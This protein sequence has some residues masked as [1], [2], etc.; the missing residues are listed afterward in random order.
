MKKMSIKQLA[1]ELDI[2][3]ATISYIMNGK[4]RE[5]RISVDLEEKVKKYAIEHNYKPNQLASGLRS[6]KTKII[7]LMVEDIA[8]VFFAT[9]A[10]HIEQIAYDKGYKIVYCSTKNDT[11]K[12]QELINTF[13]NRNVD[14]Y[15]ITP[16]NG[17][18]QDI[19]SLIE[20][21][22][23]V[24]TF[25]RASKAPN[26]S[27]VGMDNFESSFKA[28]NH[29]LEQGYQNIAL[30]TLD[31]EQSQMNE[32]L[33]GYEKA[34]KDSGKNTIIEKIEYTHRHDTAIID[35]IEK[36]LVTNSTIDAVYFATNYLAVSGLDAINRLS[37]KIPDV[38]GVVVFDDNDLFR[39]HQ[40]T[41]TAIS[42]PIAEMSVQLINIL[43]NHLEEGKKYTPQTHISPA[44]LVV[45]QSSVKPEGKE[46][47][48]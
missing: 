44:T 17:I 45:R 14:G 26:V 24:V 25:D 33:G 27:F 34:I 15:I 10:G 21:H 35:Q 19:L 1:K 32:R 7:C 13:R 36:L 22:L 29:L 9:V 48:K 39:V 40:P 37:L 23:P 5:K 8:D 20:E 18:E 31:S 2:S 47:K 38:L 42:Q 46:K 16:P 3:T 41:I 43:L 12:T 28:T 30:V 11:K 6:G 4:A